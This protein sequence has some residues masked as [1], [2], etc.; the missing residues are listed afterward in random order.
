MKN[1]NGRAAADLQLRGRFAL[2]QDFLAGLN[3]FK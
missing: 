1:K 2:Y 3:F